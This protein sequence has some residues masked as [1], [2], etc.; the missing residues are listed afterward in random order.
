MVKG[1]NNKKSWSTRK[2]KYG[3]S[4]VKNPE[5]KR[6]KQSESSSMEK[7][8]NWKGGKTITGKGYVLIMKKGHPLGSNHGYVAEH[9][10]VMEKHLGRYLKYFSKGHKD[11]EV[12]HHIDGDK[13]NNKLSNLYLCSAREHNAFGQELINLACELF[14]RGI[15]KFENGNYYV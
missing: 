6:K 7:N 3:K 2:E 15:I 14:K 11:N 8:Y 9:R 5:L 10:L 1:N 4:G 12:V 13:K